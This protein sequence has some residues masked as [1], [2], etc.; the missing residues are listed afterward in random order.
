MLTSILLYISSVIS[1]LS[2]AYRLSRSKYANMIPCSI[3]LRPSNEDEA[4]SPPP[5][6]HFQYFL[7]QTNSY[8]HT[9]QMQFDKNR[10]L[11]RTRFLIC[12]IKDCQVSGT[13]WTAV[14]TAYTGLLPPAGLAD[15]P[16]CLRRLTALWS[17][18]NARTQGQAYHYPDMRVIAASPPRL[19]VR[20]VTALPL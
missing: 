1:S 8:T 13:Y 12:V 15:C 10:V 18:F 6:Y 7:H 3:C 5:F 17:R 20:S 14:G 2:N 11:M 9:K 19:V 4:T 16:F